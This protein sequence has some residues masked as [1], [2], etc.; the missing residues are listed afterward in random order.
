MFSGEQGW[1][2]GESARLPP[3][4]PRFECQTRRHMWVEFVVGSLPCSER[5]STGTPVFP[6]PQKPTFPNSNLIWNIV[7]HFI[8][9]LWL[10]WWR[11]HS[12]CLTLNLPLHLHLQ[13]PSTPQCTSQSW[14]LQLRWSPSFSIAYCVR[15]GCVVRVVFSLIYF[16]NVI[17]CTSTEFELSCCL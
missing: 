10:G 11:E 12:L 2:S 7:K 3:M 14:S 8:V 13:I 1:C 16:R 17:F 5:F 6:S 9:S 15:V 4:C